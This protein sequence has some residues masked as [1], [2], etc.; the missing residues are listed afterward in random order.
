MHVARE[1]L[2]LSIASTVDARPTTRSRRERGTPGA[3]AH[4]ICR[5][6]HVHPRARSHTGAT[7]LAT[8]GALCTCSLWRPRPPRTQ[9]YR[10][11]PAGTGGAP[12]EQLRGAVA[13][14][15]RSER[16]VRAAHT[17][18]RGCRV[19][20]SSSAERLSAA[21]RQDARRGTRQGQRRAGG[22]EAERRGGGGGG[23]AGARTASREREGRFTRLARGRGSANPTES[24][25]R[26]R[27][28]TRRG[29]RPLSPVSPAKASSSTN[30]LGLGRA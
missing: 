12:A 14:A 15:T 27:R 1:T 6:A 24:R 28:H 30:P 2:S 26:C 18:Q 10:P 21:E 29:C 3:R 16:E 11:R 5:C 7:T 25:R 13:H 8:P 9:G 22:A 4:C 17:A 23:A 20:T 19:G